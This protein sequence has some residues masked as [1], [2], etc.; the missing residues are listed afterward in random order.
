VVASDGTYLLRF[1]SQDPEA[2]YSLGITVSRGIPCD[3]DTGEPNDG[4][5]AATAIN[6]GVLTDRV[7]CPR[8]PDWFVMER[9]LSQRLELG[10]QFNAL[11]GDLDLDL[12]A[13]DGQTLVA[14]SATAGDSELV[15]V[16]DHPGTRFFARVYGAD[17]TSNRYELQLT[18]TPR[19]TGRQP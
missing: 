15:V 16:E 17:Q 5:G 3:D 19:Q 1:Q 13:A 2:A 18:L 10:I 11:Q 8:N 9:A 14:R 4:P 7:I 6:A 12:L